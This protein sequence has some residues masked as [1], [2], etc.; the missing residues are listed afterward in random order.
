MDV[1]W[2]AETVACEFE[3]KAGGDKFGILSQGGYMPIFYT[4]E[5]K[6]DKGNFNASYNW[7]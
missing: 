3:L 2:A 4:T 1:Y 5:W 7:W 6:T